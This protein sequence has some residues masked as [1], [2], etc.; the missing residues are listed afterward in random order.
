MHA[1]GIIERGCCRLSI[2]TTMESWAHNFP[3]AAFFGRRAR[4]AHPFSCAVGDELRWWEQYDDGDASTPD[5]IVSK[6]DVLTGLDASPDASRPLS[7]AGQD[8]TTYP[9]KHSPMQQV[10]NFGGKLFTTP[11]I[12]PV[13]Y[14]GDSAET[15]ITSMLIP[16]GEVYFNS[17]PVMTDPVILGIGSSVGLQIPVGQSKTIPVELYSDGPT[18]GPWTLSAIDVASVYNM[19]TEALGVA[20]DKTSGQNGDVVL[21]TIT[22]MASDPLYGGDL[23]ILVSTLGNT[24]NVWTGA[25]GN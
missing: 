18:S 2:S 20:F 9:A 19:E 3:L 12:V 6:P 7:E 24:K 8:V 10:V 22:A 15:T 5:G 23:F 16:A 14:S 17:A 11:N 21:M 4:G 25:V 13:F 1:N